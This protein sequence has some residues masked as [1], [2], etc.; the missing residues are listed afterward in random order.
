MV[1]RTFTDVTDH[2]SGEK[3]I[4]DVRIEGSR[5]ALPDRLLLSCRIAE[6]KKIT[7]FGD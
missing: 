3:T 7:K 4:P 5:A 6:K 2:K 1:T